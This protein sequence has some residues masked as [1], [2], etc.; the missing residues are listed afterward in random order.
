MRKLTRWIGAA[1]AAVA[2]ASVVACGTKE[3]PQVEGLYTYEHAFNYDYQG[4][5]FDVSETGTMDFRAD[6]SVVDS[7]RQ[8][9]V[10][11]L[12][13]GGVATIVFDYVSPSRWHL[14]GEELHFAGIKESF[15]ME[16]LETSVEGCDRQRADSLAC[17]IVKLVGGSIDYEYTFHLDTLTASELRWS[18]TYRDGHADTWTFQ[19]EE[20]R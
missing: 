9:Y 13:E 4:H 6:G 5:H 10:A 7:A 20:A 1:V 12:A 14:D 3:E 17:A 11:T 2:M 8:V 18:Y 16:P 15:R 19:R